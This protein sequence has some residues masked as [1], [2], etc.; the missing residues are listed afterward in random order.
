MPDSDDRIE[1]LEQTVRR[2][3]AGMLVLA[4]VLMGTFLIVVILATREE[5]TVRR[6]AIVDND[7]KER[8]VAATTSSGEASLVHYDPEGEM[9]IDAGTFSD[10][11]ARVIHHD[12]DG[13]RRITAV[14]LP[15]GQ[16]AII[17]SDGEGVRAWG[18]TS[19]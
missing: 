13:K 19:E 3:R 15:D 4:A 9:R 17:L 1:N 14:T 18:E 8:I 5:L 12:R 6:L 2:L 10:G 7:G 11:Q 16:A